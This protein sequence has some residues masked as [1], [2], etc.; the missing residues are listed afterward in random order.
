MEN[1]LNELAQADRILATI[2]VSQD[3]VFAM[4]AARQKISKAC[5]ELTTLVEKEDSKKEEVENG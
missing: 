2:P 4:A 5:T 1:I 3:A